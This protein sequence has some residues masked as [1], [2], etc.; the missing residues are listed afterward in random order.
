MKNLIIV[1]SVFFAIGANAQV[2]KAAPAK[3]VAKTEE[4]TV[5]SQF[6]AE[7][8]GKKDAAD[9]ATFIPMS[10]ELQLKLENIFKTRHKMLVNN[11]SEERKQILNKS[12]ETKLESALGPVDFQKLKSNPKLMNTLLK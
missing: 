5:K 8:A 9:V 12:I 11:L 1:A 3:V 4:V 10:P 6:S 2:K 7:E